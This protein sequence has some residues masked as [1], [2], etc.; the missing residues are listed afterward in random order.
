MTHMGLSLVSSKDSA[1]W[2]DV[3]PL[4]SIW[5]QQVWQGAGVAKPHRTAVLG[6]PADL[7]GQDG[8]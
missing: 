7:W 5:V 8:I 3:V 6:A 2:R 4:G 1:P